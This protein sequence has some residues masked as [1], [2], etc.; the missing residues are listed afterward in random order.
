MAPRCSLPRWAAKK[1]AR[2]GV[3]AVSALARRGRDEGA[4]ARVLTYHRFG[5]A[6]RD[7]YCVGVPAFE[8]QMRWLAH[9]GLALSLDDVTALVAG[10]D[11]APEGGVL[12][13]IDD[14]CRS[15]IENALPVLR[16]WGIPAVVYVVVGSLG[17]GRG[18]DR[19]QP[20]DYMTWNDVETLLAT[21]LV[22]I[23]SHAYHHR[24]VARRYA[25]LAF[26]EAAGSRALLEERLGTPVRSFAYPFGT[27]RDFSPAT[28]RALAAAGY[29]TAFTS[30][31]GP[32]RPGLDPLELPRIKVEG[33]DPRWVFRT[34]P[35]GGLDPWR[36]IDRA[37]TPLQH[38]S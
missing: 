34:L 2:I 18:L 7:P 11:D 27:L 32:L 23:G 6:A 9:A 33:G 21:G 5:D 25:T 30:Q 31:H 24:S 35:A 1:A 37:L 12:V 26:D 20:E 14:G 29:T 17:R 8:A 4:R 36:L 15:T 38:A 3:A 10:G 19:D 13:T 22:T 16:Q 28:R